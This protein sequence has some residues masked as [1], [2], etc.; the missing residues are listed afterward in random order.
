VVVLLTLA[1][2]ALTAVAWAAGAVCEQELRRALPPGDSPDGVVAVE[3]LAAAVRLVEP[4]LQPWRHPGQPI[5]EGERG[6][7]A[8]RFL[9]GTGLL[10]PGWTPERHD[11]G[12]WQTMH[13]RFAAWY[14][15]RPA[16][17]EGGSRAAMVADMAYTLGEVSEALRPLAVF[18]TGPEDEVTFFAVVWNW[19]PVP[20]LVLLRTPAGLYLGEGDGAERA[21]PVLAAMS[22]CA[23]RFDGYVYA[24]EDLA[25]QLFGQQGE[26]IFRVLGSDPPAADLPPVFEAD[27]VLGVFTFDDPALAGV[28]ALSGGVEGPSVS[29]ATAVRLLATVRTNIGLDGIFFHTA[30]P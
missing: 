26:S 28:R 13:D 19:T 10:P 7:E 12:A 2:L 23:L 18:A 24:P 25:I 6:A 29:A 11:V 30:F 4:A 14:R 3:L 17:V 15:A 20:R 21:A 27:R 22:N 8:A 5:P 16:R 1:A 9:A